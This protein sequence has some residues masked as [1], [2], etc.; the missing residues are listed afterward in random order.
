MRRNLGAI[1]DV[2]VVA[3]DTLALKRGTLPLKIKPEEKKES[4]NPFE[5]FVRAVAGVPKDDALRQERDERKRKVKKPK[6][7]PDS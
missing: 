1:I 2:S 5:R 6:A 7:A 4:S 3:P